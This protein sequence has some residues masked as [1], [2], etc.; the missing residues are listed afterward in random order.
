MGAKEAVPNTPPTL[1]HP[2]LKWVGGKGR[3][4]SQLRSLLPHRFGRYFEPFLGGGA[5]F[6]GLRPKVATLADVNGELVDCYRA[7]RDSVEDVV[8]ELKR[9]RYDK[10]LY[11]TV[12]AQNPAALRLPERAARMLFLNRAGFNGLYRV[13]RAGTFNVPFGRYDNPRLCDAENLR[14]CSE[15][16]R[17]VELS[18]QDFGDTVNGADAGDLVYFDPPYAPVSETANFTRYVPDQFRWTD[19]QRLAK[20]FESLASRGVLVILSSSDTPGIRQLYSAFQID[21]VSAPRRINSD[22]TRR[23]PVNE[24]VVRSFRS[25]VS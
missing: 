4:L 25:E 21:E 18:C 14:A 22:P 1:A 23:G 20:T 9:Y 6:F 17:N 12:R 5:V 19:Q 8:D 24:L 11:Y 10:D 7:I 16:L 3:L 15:A 13:N 2:F